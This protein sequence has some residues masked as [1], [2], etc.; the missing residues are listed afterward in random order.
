M[1]EQICNSE[2]S[3]KIVS[4]VPEG[5][6]RANELLGNTL[7]HNVICL[8]LDGIISDASLIKYPILH[9]LYLFY[10]KDPKL[11][12]EEHI[13]ILSD[14]IDKVK[15]T[16]SDICITTNRNIRTVDNILW[17]SNLLLAQLETALNDRLNLDIPFPVFLGMDR[18]VPYEILE[19]VNNNRRFLAMDRMIMRI[20]KND[21]RPIRFILIS[22]IDLASYTE[23]FFKDSL[24][25]R[26][27]DVRVEVISVISNRFVRKGVR[28]F[29]N[30]IYFIRQLVD[31]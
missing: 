1:S 13:Q 7:Y 2:T 15:E 20:R 25:K 8:D 16:G 26:Y 24:E 11:I 30:F 19:Y 17:R 10:R 9:M 3:P 14:L 31:V 18:M 6:N 22:D 4:S 28:V 23:Y 21:T 5:I 27:G 29:R 12:P